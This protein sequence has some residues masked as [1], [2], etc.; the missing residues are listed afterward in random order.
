MNNPKPNNFHCTHN[1][2]NKPSKSLM[3]ALCTIH[4]TLLLTNHPN[5]VQSRTP[6]P[7]RLHHHRL[8]PRLGNQILLQPRSGP[9]ASH[10]ASPR[11]ESIRHH[12]D[13]RGVRRLECGDVRF[14]SGDGGA[15]RA[16]SGGR[17]WGWEE[18]GGGAGGWWGFGELDGNVEG[19]VVVFCESVDLGEEGMRRM[20]LMQ[21]LWQ[22]ALLRCG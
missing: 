3:T 2:D 18:E 22:W 10:D 13:F 20:L 4:T 17:G 7:N 11:R 19:G 5:P 1:S 9:I 16:V 12:F 8:L 21:Q 15:E 14:R 6:S